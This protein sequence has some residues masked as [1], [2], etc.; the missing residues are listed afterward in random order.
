[1]IISWRRQWRQPR[2]L[3]TKSRSALLP[4]HRPAKVKLTLPRQ[5]RYQDIKEQVL[6]AL[7]R[8]D[9]VQ[10]QL[11]PA[12]STLPEMIVALALIWGGY[13]FAAQRPEDG[14]RLRLGGAV[15]DFI[16]YTGRPIVIRVQGDYWHSLPN[17]RRRDAMQLLRLI[18]RGYTVIDLWEHDLY[19]AWTQGTIVLFVRQSLQGAI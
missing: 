15:V 5:L 6:A 14:G 17:H 16:V 4:M 3:G 1:M 2:E 8:L 18:S 19:Q 10:Q 7:A 12:G 13:R 11:I 9:T